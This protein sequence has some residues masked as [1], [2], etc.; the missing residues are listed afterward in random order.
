[1]LSVSKKDRGQHPEKYKPADFPP[2][3]SSLQPMS[4]YPESLMHLF[5]GIVKA[6]VKLSFCAFRE[7]QKLNSFFKLKGTNNVSKI[8][9]MN[10]PWFPLMHIQSEKILVW[11]Q[12]II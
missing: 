9:S 3:W 4:I 7:D 2:L 10:L 1:M 5:S 11:D 8:G 6:V 12:T